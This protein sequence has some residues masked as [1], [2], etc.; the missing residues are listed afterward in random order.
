M[1]ADAYAAWAR[2]GLDR[3]FEPVLA[4][5]LD[6]LPDPPRRLLDVGCGEGRLGSRLQRVGYE[7]TGVDASAAMVELARES[8]V[9]EAADACALPFAGRSFD[10]AVTVHALMEIDD[11]DGVLREIARVLAPGGALVAVIEHPF[12]SGRR[13]ARYD[14]V[15]RYRWELSH[16]GVDLALG[17]IHR[18]LGAYAGALE[19]AGLA[20]DALREIDVAGWR[21]LSLALR[22][23]RA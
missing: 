10:A 14:D 22:C 20:L 12:V 18:P 7:V 23:K 19:R 21:P 3:S 8:H 11:L 1:R 9:A 2:S 13:V 5:V 16:G 15:A 6:L 4:T 17:G